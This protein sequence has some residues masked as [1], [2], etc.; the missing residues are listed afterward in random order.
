MGQRRMA[1]RERWSDSM[2]L[3]QDTLYFVE[4]AAVH[5]LGRGR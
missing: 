2:Y 4:D 1:H 3:R 5:I